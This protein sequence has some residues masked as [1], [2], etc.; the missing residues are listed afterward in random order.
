[1]HVEGVRT[2]RC[3]RPLVLA[4]A[5][6]LFAT[7][8][9]AQQRSLTAPQRAV[10][11]SLQSLSDQ[12]RID[13]I[14]A[15][16]AAELP[17]ARAADDSLFV[18][19][20]VGA[21]GSANTMHNRAGRAG[22]DLSEAL[23]LA[24]ALGDSASVGRLALWSARQREVLG[25]Q[26]A[27]A[28]FYRRALDLGRETASPFYMG[29]GLAGLA[30]DRTLEG[31]YAQA[32]SLY[33]EAHACAV[34]ADDSFTILWSRNGLGICY[35][36]LGQFARADTVLAATW[37]EAGRRGLRMV[38]GTALNNHAGLLEMLGRP[39]EAMQGYRRSRELNLAAGAVRE[40]F[41]AGMNVARCQQQ[42]GQLDAAAN[43]VAELIGEARQAG[44]RDML[45]GALEQLALIRMDQGRPA[46]AA[47][48]CR[49]GLAMTD[50][51][52]PRH[53][54]LLRLALAGAL[55]RQDSLDAALA[56]ARAAE[57]L[58]I[59][60][61]DQH[62]RAETAV[63][64]GA[65]LMAREDYEDAAEVFAAAATDVEAA[66]MVTHQLSLESR[67][68]EALLLAERPE[69]ARPWL[70]DALLLWESTRT[71]P[72]EPRWR[73]WRSGAAHRLFESLAELTLTDPPDAAPAVR[74]RRCFDV[75][76][77]FKARTLLERT[78]GPGRE[79]ADPRPVTLAE[80]QGEVLR[81]G[82][83]FVDCYVGE[84]HGLIF[85]VTR[86]TLLLQ[87]LRGRAAVAS[88]VDVMEGQIDAGET[89]FASAPLVTI[90]RALTTTL[91]A[92]PGDAGLPDLLRQARALMWSPDGPLH[93]VPLALVCDDRGL[94]AARCPSATFL[95]NLRRQQEDASPA[96]VSVLAVAGLTDLDGRPLTG[97]V[98]E[99]QWL[100]EHF[101]PVDAVVDTSAQPFG[102]HD[103]AD[104]GLLHLAAHA[105]IDAQSPW[106]CALILGSADAP[107]R[108]MAG[109]VAEMDLGARLA[110]LAS[111]NSASGAVLSGEGMLGL[112]S[113][114]L[115]AGVP[116]VVATL[117]PVEDRHAE[118]F[119]RRFYDELAADRSVADAL[120]RTRNWLRTQPATAAPDHWAA[121]VLLGE[122]SG[123]VTLARTRK[124]TPAVWLIAGG[125]LTAAMVT[126]LARRRRQRSSVKARV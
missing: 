116:A 9:A 124:A 25:Q 49:E 93:R 115:A 85:A 28:V 101:Q 114:F 79:L 109:A 111:C 87:P 14:D 97:T 5:L 69:A 110:V 40:A 80:L 10:I 112:A 121:Y 52:I 67:A 1:M 113:G 103:P 96:A 65:I 27:S 32:E 17:A 8:A 34:A 81:P 47:R 107:R 100:A 18:M 72:Q 126:L 16:V 23:R 64:A 108:L 117:W 54:V 95:A 75:L 46:L 74:R 39:G 98:R 60:R 58:P 73:E 6:W 51:L 48:H 63:T 70:H 94:A 33:T 19:R 99:V 102:G 66:G 56:A 12:G 88:A 31:D 122:G 21:R 61:E 36:N 45:P 125:A 29:R 11:D 106:N 92:V 84:R 104:Y 68:G 123:T 82:E 91:D 83:I 86:D 57:A 105:E 35:T 42:L 24:T 20:L 41:P 3:G 53:E 77:H 26:E 38:E 37:R 119:T 120:R 89:G 44:F 76:Q 90:A 71:L 4:A 2:R 15:L 62:M 59:V 50:A 13:A 43:T 55:A 78:L 118:R 7:G 30:W 22:D